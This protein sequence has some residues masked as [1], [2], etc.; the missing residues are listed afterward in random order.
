MLEVEKI[1]RSFGNLRAVDGLDL[2]VEQG[3]IHGLIGP[4]GSGKSTTMNLIS[5][6][7]KPDSGTITFNGQRIDGMRQDKVAGLGLVRSFQ[8]T[9]VFA[10]QTVFEAV[11]LGA[12]A[13]QPGGFGLT[14]LLPF[15]KQSEAANIARDA[16]ARLGLDDV[17]D[18]RAANLP[19]GLQRV[20]S[21][22]TALATGPRLLLLDEPLAGLN[23][24]EKADVAD[25]IEELRDAGVTILLVEHD[26]KSVL[27]LC[28]TITVI[29]FGARIANGAPSA[30]ARDQ[31][32]INAYLGERGARHVA[33]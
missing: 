16:I 11:R 26:I 10:D 19:G 17:A 25:R 33:N 23:A 6:T 27:R 2:T 12:M 14:R 21:I 9:R 8:L 22:A 24:T 15:P 29:N 3:T 7:L 4:N 1:T 18:R 32:V 31:T 5:G 28:D 30:I 20:L 13:A